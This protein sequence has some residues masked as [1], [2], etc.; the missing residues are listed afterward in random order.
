MFYYIFHAQVFL[1]IIYLQSSKISMPSNFKVNIFEKFHIMEIPL[2]SIINICLLN[3]VRGEKLL[4]AYHIILGSILNV[5]IDTI[6]RNLHF[7]IEIRFV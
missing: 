6:L 2:R 1:E 5:V 3:H 4:H 7:R